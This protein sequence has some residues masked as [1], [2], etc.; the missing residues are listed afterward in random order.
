MK[1]NRALHSWAFLPESEYKPSDITLSHYAVNEV[2]FKEVAFEV[3]EQY[4]N[5]EWLGDILPELKNWEVFQ[6]ASDASKFLKD[7]R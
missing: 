4:R 2:V 7:Y 1:F 3:Y 5:L 6:D